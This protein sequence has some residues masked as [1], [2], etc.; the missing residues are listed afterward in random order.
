MKNLIFSNLFTSKDFASNI[1]MTADPYSSKIFSNSIMI[2]KSGGSSSFFKRS[3]M[4][5]A[6]STTITGKSSNLKRDVGI[7]LL[8]AQ[9][10]SASPKEAKRK[11]KE[12]E[13]EVQKKLKQEQQQQ[14]LLEKEEKLKAQQMHQ[15]KLEKEASEKLL[16]EE[17]NLLK[18]RAESRPVEN[19]ENLTRMDTSTSNTDESRLTSHFD[20]GQQPPL[21]SHQSLKL[22]SFTTMPTQQVQQ[23]HILNSMK[24]NNDTDYSSATSS[25]FIYQHQSPFLSHSLPQQQQLQ[26]LQQQQQQHYHTESQQQKQEHF[27]FNQHN[28]LPQQPSYSTAHEVLHDNSSVFMNKNNLQYSGASLPQSMANSQHQLGSLPVKQQNLEENRQTFNN[29]TVEHVSF[30]NNNSNNNN[31]NNSNSNTNPCMS[32]MPSSTAAQAEQSKRTHQSLSLTVGR[33]RH[34]LESI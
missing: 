17:T 15:E 14:E 23:A 9:E 26:R 33:F 25:P 10:Q 12:Y 24:T 6:N 19:L 7:K 21:Q 29:L 18:E 8:D 30:S 11:R 27:Q 16:E 1:G 3:M 5:S 34:V 20:F 22:E 2:N 32:S 31:N 28:S 13:K 4:P